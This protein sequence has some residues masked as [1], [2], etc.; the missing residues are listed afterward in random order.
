[1]KIL[2]N[3]LPI[4]KKVEMRRDNRFRMIVAQGSGVI[5]LELFYGCVLL[6]VS[7]LLSTQLSS[8]RELARGGASLSPEKSESESYEK[9]F[10][11][12]NATV[13]EISQLL[14]RHVS[15]EKFFWSLETATPSGVFYTKII[16]KNDFL[17]SANGTAPNREALLLLE[18]NMNDSDCFRA[19]DNGPMIPLSDK[20]EKK[21]I[22]FQLDAVIEKK[23]LIGAKEP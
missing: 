2:L 11:E 22:E 16:T 8:V 14:D 15:W 6:G 1:M 17:I 20:L 23:C 21:D 3:L 9:T 7:W 4:E 12:T 19:P 5:F 18:K 10:H 13:A